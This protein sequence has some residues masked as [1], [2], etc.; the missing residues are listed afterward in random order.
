MASSNST[1]PLI[2]LETPTINLKEDY[3]LVPW[4]NWD[5]W[6]YV[7]LSLFSSPSSVVANALRR[8]TA[9]RSR[10]CL[11][12]A[13]EVS[14][15]FVEIQ[16]KDPHFSG[17]S[18]NGALGSDEMLSMLY[19][20]AIMRLVN[21]LIEK[22]RERQ[23]LSIA[24]AA[25]MIGMPRMLI[26]I[27]HEGSH[28]ELPSLNLLR[29]ASV[30]ALDWLKSY[31]WERQKNTIPYQSARSTDVR[32]EIKSRLRELASCMKL[33][34]SSGSCSSQ[35]K[36]A[37]VHGRNKLFSLVACKF[38]SSKKVGSKKQKKILKKLVRLYSFFSSDVVCVLLK[39]L[40]RPSNSVDMMD[41]PENFQIKSSLEVVQ[42]A[43]DEWKSVITKFSKS[44]PDLLLSLLGALLDMIE[45]RKASRDDFGNENF[46]LSKYDLETQTIGVLS[47]LFSW[48]VLVLKGLNLSLNGSQGRDTESDCCIPRT[49]LTELVRRC[50]HAAGPENDELLGSA[51]L[52]AKMGGNRHLNERIEKL[53]LIASLYSKRSEDDLSDD[54]TNEFS[55]QDKYIHQ[56]AQKFELLKLRKF[57][58]SNI[59]KSQDS[60][61]ED[62]IIWTV[63]K[64][65]N[66]C[67][68]GM[69]PRAVGLSGYLPVLDYGM[70]NETTMP[71]PSIDNK[72]NSEPTH[73]NKRDASCDIEREDESSIKR[74]RVTEDSSVPLPDDTNGVSLSDCIKG[75]LLIN[76]F[77]QKVGD[78]ESQNILSR[79]RVLVTTKNS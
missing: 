60:G 73:C 68:I 32:K 35:V 30:L 39:F 3:K 53:S 48:L 26:D 31:Y 45:I 67:P 74:M 2:D 40:L 28:R 54:V 11:P 7:R 62:G 46:S 36:R 51:L 72:E 33:K 22:T 18:S 75:R 58:N 79:L 16:Q 50:L 15:S 25:E 42:G 37:T 4:L 27:R 9:W 44:E 78:Q 52:I 1:T 76:G 34:H 59:S 70:V 21:G 17:G 69:L 43:F 57:G 63:A 56:A 41:T 55:D 19:T 47:S 13:V 71:S 61:A 64:S 12:V 14:A 20:M 38:K 24:V 65:W 49:T 6:D 66:P 8:V 5:E 29:R 23:K 77:Y 10:G